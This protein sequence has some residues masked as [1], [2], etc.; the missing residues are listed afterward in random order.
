[1]NG[2]RWNNPYGDLAS[3]AVLARVAS[4][5]KPKRW[6]E[7]G[8]LR[9]DSAEAIFEAVPDSEA[10]LVDSDTAAF[11]S[12]DGG[13]IGRQHGHPPRPDLKEKAQGW[14]Y[15]IIE[16]DSREVL[17]RLKQKFDFIHIDGTHDEHCF[18]ADL[19]NSIELLAEGGS[20]MAHDFHVTRS[21]PNTMVGKVFQENEEKLR[22]LF[23]SVEVLEA[24]NPQGENQ[25][26][27]KLGRY[28][29]MGH[30]EPR[31]GA[32]TTGARS[33]GRGGPAMAFFVVGTLLILM[34]ATMVF[35][36]TKGRRSKFPDVSGDGRSE[37][38]RS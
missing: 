2:N 31:D 3:R 15:Q 13:P 6:L 24:L 18:L 17:P 25:G 4:E 35:L 36:R 26:Y 8:V 5:V 34:R 19:W 16:G 10:V 29:K 38:E 23:E 1:M 7:I 27:L 30:A 28:R 32:T 22:P 37:M 11:L 33:S 14:R 12:V 21:A 9:G 20:I